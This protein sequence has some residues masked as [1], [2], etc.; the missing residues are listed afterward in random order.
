MPLLLFPIN[1]V[2]LSKPEGISI[3]IVLDAPSP[4]KN[5]SS[6]AEATS[7]TDWRAV[8][9]CLMF[10]LPE[11][12]L[13]N[14]APTTSM[15]ISTAA[16]KII[17]SRLACPR[18]L[19]RPACPKSLFSLSF[20][21]LL[22]FH[23]RFLIIGDIGSFMTYAILGG[24]FNILHSGHEA[25]L[26]AAAHSKHILIGL[27]SDALAKRL[28]IY[29]I[30]P[31]AVRCKRLH[32]L[33]KKLG[34]ASRSSIFELE[35]AFGPAIFDCGAD[36]LVVS[37]ETAKA[38]ANINRIRKRKGLHPLR[39]IVVPLVMAQDCLPISSRRIAQGIINP[40]GRRLK[41]LRVA[42]GS[43][44]PSKLR[45]VRNALKQAFPNVRLSVRGFSVDSRVHEQPVGFSR[46]WQGAIN[47]AKGAGKKW[48]SADYCI[49]L[50]NGL[51][52]MGGRHYDTQLCAMLDIATGRITSGCSMGF[53]LP[54]KVEKLVVGPGRKV[55]SSLGDAVD[56]LSG[57]KNIGRKKGALY[58]L[59]RGLME[60]SQMTEQAV[61]CA[62]V[63]RRSPV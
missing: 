54:E 48:H 6:A 49:G 29:P 40:Q 14:T 27:S 63:E 47:R 61:L 36:T 8:S 11:V 25:L 19:S 31:Y 10:S 44:N 1:E 35:D 18:L 42:V 52:P 33:L 57:Q 56:S 51:L 39:L 58:F 62:L 22:H 41:P 60:R 32:L 45:G 24:T 30:S 21:M 28:K 59:S 26:R 17:V 53:P 7:C 34:M 50:E 55:R 3:E 37:K 43:A 46:T 16:N 15:T 20:L 12:V 23:L 2:I 4:A 13:G 5:T 38:G 9:T